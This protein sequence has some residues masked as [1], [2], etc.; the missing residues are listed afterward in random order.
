MLVYTKKRIVEDNSVRVVNLA[1]YALQRFQAQM[2]G[3]EKTAGL[4]TDEDV[5]AWITVSHREKDAE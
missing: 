4:L 2:A 1:I 5:A 3:E